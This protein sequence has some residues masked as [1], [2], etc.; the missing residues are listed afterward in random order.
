MAR[1]TSTDVLSSRQ[2]TALKAILGTGK[3]AASRPNLLHPSSNISFRTLASTR[4]PMLTHKVQASTRLVLHNTGNVCRRK[5]VRPPSLIIF[6]TDKSHFLSDGNTECSPIRS[7]EF[8]P[9]T[10]DCVP[11]IFS[12]RASAV[13][14]Y[15]PNRG[16]S[17]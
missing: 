17:G 5:R 13:S 12:H 15:L 10:L 14:W 11:E 9:M 16:G 7:F 2:H 4:P 8:C 6:S 3:H 1:G